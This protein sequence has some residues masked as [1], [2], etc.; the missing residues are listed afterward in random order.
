M[1]AA[2]TIDLASIR[3]SPAPRGTALAP[4]QLAD[5]F[6]YVTPV[7]TLA[8]LSSTGFRVTLSPRGFVTYPRVGTTWLLQDGTGE[9]LLP[10]SGNGYPLLSGDGA[11]LF[12]VRTDLTGLTELSARGEPAWTR[13]FPT[14]MTTA[15][16][17]GDWTAVGLLDG[18]LALLDRGG[19][20]AFQRQVPGSR[21][22]VVLGCAVT[23]DGSRL[24][25]VAGIDP[26]YVIVFERR[27]T[28]WAVVSQA[29]LGTDF[30]REVR[31]GFA[32]DGRWLVCE[33]RGGVAVVLVAGGH[34]QVVSMRG[35]LAGLAFPAAPAP[36]S[37]LLVSR[38]GSLIDVAL[39]RPAGPGNGGST[40]A[41]LHRETITLS[42]AG[43]PGPYL[44]AA[45]ALGAA[46]GRLVLAAAER[47]TGFSLEER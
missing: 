21:I 14:L 43:E 15:S 28:S 12:L 17:S 9:V 47:V 18:T 7:G 19:A 25:A 27:G 33:G 4:F 8:Y 36:S 45:G 23:P 38:S 41:L 16:V 35:T 34:P 44:G 1:L 29:E 22:P 13:D 46:D 32:P 10:F 6:G 3:P 11:R 30:R 2:W 26:Q 40:P 37:C 20:V 39:V 5:R 24:A 42:G 31:I